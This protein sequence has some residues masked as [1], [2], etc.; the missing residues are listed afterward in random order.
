MPKLSVNKL[1]QGA[2]RDIFGALVHALAKIDNPSLLEDFLADLLTPT[3]RLMLAK[4]LMAAVLLQR[5]YGYS[6]ICRT[7]KLSKAT[8]YTIKRD[9]ERGR[10]GYQ[11]VFGLFFDRAAG[12]KIMHAIERALSAITLPIKGSSSRMRRWKRAL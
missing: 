3:E 1:S 12:R 11:R 4:R 7:L 5:G 9:L 8:V 10:N 6:A 2:Q